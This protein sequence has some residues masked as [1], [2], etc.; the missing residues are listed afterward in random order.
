[1]QN[2]SVAPPAVLALSMFCVQAAVAAEP[3]AAVVEAQTTK[4]ADLA[5][6][7]AAVRV[8]RDKSTGRLRKPSDDEL[9]ELLAA[10]AAQRAATGRPDPATAPPALSVRQ[11]S[12]G[13]LSAVL[14]TEH[15]VTVKAVRAPDGRL[16]RAHTHPSMEHPVPSRN[17]PTE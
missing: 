16:V 8:V 6:G 4:T 15:L 1:M 10:E 5:T 3:Q 12:N 13:M 14:G 2:R 11:H 17:G 9:A 7:A